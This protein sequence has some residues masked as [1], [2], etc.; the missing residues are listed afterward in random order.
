MPVL[1]GKVLGPSRQPLSRISRSVSLRLNMRVLHGVPLCCAIFFLT[2]CFCLSQPMPSCW[3]QKAYSASRQGWTPIANGPATL[4]SI[5]KWSNGGYN[6]YP[7]ATNCSSGVV[8]SSY[9]DMLVVYFPT[10][11]GFSGIR[12]RNGGN[13]C[14]GQLRYDPSFPMTNATTTTPA[15]SAT[16][17]FTSFSNGFG[18]RI[19]GAGGGIIAAPISGVRV[20]G[21][22]GSTGYT[23][24]ALASDGSLY[25]CGDKGGFVKVT[26]AL[27]LAFSYSVGQGNFRGSPAVS[28]DNTMAFAVS[29]AGPLLFAVATASNTVL[30]NF[31]LQGWSDAL[32]STPS[33]SADSSRV[34]V[35]DATRVY[36]IAAATGSQLWVSS[37]ITSTSNYMCRDSQLALSPDG[38]AVYAGSISGLTA[39]SALTG[40]VLWNFTANT[41]IHGVSVDATGNIFFGDGAGNA[42]ALSPSGAILWV[43]NAATSISPSIGE[44]HAPPAIDSY[45]NLIF[46]SLSCNVFALCGG[47]VASS[48]PT[49]SRTP[50]WTST[51][52]ATATPTPTRSRIVCPAGAFLNVSSCNLCPAGTYTSSAG[53]AS[54]QQCPGGHYCGAGTSSWARLNCGRGN[55]CPEGSGAPTPCPYQVPPSGGWGALQVQGPAF[56]VDTANCLNHCFWNFTSGEGMLSKC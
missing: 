52:S 22:V 46:I 7:G 25:F 47:S 34:Y 17:V 50:S 53:S 56:L 8:V 31:T 15:L 5:S 44:I 33:V 48:T 9:S 37:G 32:C 51:S 36:S 30:W 20:A 21:S 10:S 29:D 11:V 39:L 12:G 49:P 42:V 18:Y 26:S 4:G 23:G 54:C 16:S 14:A 2:W 24:V 55:Y 43:Y 6:S 41:N 45:G 19:A 13:T 1:S 3:A 38:S 27:V 40:Q 28:P 35:G